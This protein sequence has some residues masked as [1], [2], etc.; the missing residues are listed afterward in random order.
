MKLPDYV[1]RLVS[2]EYPGTICGS[3]SFCVPL[4]SQSR[5]SPEQVQKTFLMTYRDYATA[6]AIL[7]IL[8]RLYQTTGFRVRQNIVALMRT[9]L[10]HLWTDFSED[11]DVR[12]RLYWSSWSSPAM[13]RCFYE[14]FHFQQFSWTHH[15][16]PKLLHRANILI[17]GCSSARRNGDQLCWPWYER[18]RYLSA[19]IK[20][21]ILF[22]S[23]NQL[24]IYQHFLLMPHRST[25]HAH[26]QCEWAMTTRKNWWVLAM[27]LWHIRANLEM[28][29]A[30]CYSSKVPL[31]NYAGKGRQLW[32]GQEAFHGSK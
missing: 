5:Y 12:D 16:H 17:P 26:L 19:L 29:Y 3:R 9:W 14:Y 2:V 32:V 10:T 30:G 4:L 23:I 18:S 20:K 25:R 6:P 24:Y 8:S 22:F 21:G 31:M 13:I 1:E 11:S 15:S 27:L 28:L 7:L